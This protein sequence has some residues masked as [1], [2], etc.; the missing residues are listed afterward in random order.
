MLNTKVVSLSLAITSAVLY[1]ACAAAFML[2]PIGTLKF[3]NTW[4]HGIDLTIIASEKPIR[5]VN[6]LVGLINITV[7]SVVTGIIFSTIY[8]SFQRRGG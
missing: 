6:I 7:A 4:L 5:M 2:F 1:I 8:N 3:F